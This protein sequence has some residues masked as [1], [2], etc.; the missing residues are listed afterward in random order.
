MTWDGGPGY[1]KEM[2]GHP[3]LHVQMLDPWDP[4]YP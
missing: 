3:K 1:D 2:L 4:A